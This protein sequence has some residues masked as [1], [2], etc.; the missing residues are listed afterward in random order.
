MFGGMVSDGVCA[1]PM[2]RANTETISHEM[3]ERRDITA[4][5]LRL[6]LLLTAWLAPQDVLFRASRQEERLRNKRKRRNK[7]KSPPISHCVIGG[8]DVGK[9][10]LARS[11]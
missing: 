1:K 9:Q 6:L 8:E 7:R 3:C 2:S 5:P 10:S 4:L 11:A